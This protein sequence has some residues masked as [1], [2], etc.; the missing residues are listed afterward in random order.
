MMGHMNRT[1]KDPSTPQGRKQKA[2]DVQATPT[3]TAAGAP[4][5]SS[6]AKTTR[7]TPARRSLGGNAP[8][9]LES[10]GSLVWRLLEDSDNAV[11]R[12][13]YSECCHCDGI[14]TDGF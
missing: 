9:A 8:G 1:S 13:T 11:F 14:T 5:L 7:K 3:S 10:G 2:N 12:H 4:H 6:G